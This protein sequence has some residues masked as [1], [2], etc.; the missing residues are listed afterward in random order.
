MGLLGGGG[1]GGGGGEVWW[2]VLWG[3]G[4]VL[5]YRPFPLLCFGCAFFA[6]QGRKILH[7]AVGVGKLDEAK[8]FPLSKVGQTKAEFVALNP[9]VL[10]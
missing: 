7:K 1:R 5:T 8:V 3:R 6:H 9:K 2:G 10:V 4:G